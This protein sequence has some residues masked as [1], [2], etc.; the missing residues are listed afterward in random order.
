MIFFGVNTGL[1]AGVISL[2]GRI[3]YLRA[4]RENFGFGYNLLSS[5][6]LAIMGMTLVMASESIGYTSGLL[7]LL[8][9]FFVRDAYR[10]FARDRATRM[11][12][13]S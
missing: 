11:P 3:P 8:F 7:Y 2:H 4:W 13:G 1:V 5:A 9:L 10:R 12:A 6:V